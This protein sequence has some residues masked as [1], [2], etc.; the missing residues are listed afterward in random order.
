MVETFKE[1]E[2]KF[3]LMTGLHRLNYWDEIFLVNILNNI[4]SE[5]ELNTYIFFCSRILIDGCDLITSFPLL[6][7][8]K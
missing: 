6:V 3:V 4:V 5:K 8:K 1:I 2:R 7:L